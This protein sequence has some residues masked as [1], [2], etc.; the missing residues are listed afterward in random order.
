MAFDDLV[1]ILDSVDELDEILTAVVGQL[2][3]RDTP[4][5]LQL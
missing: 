3:A 2:D 5:L 1:D 4:T